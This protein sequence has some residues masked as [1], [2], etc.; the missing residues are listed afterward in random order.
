MSK[1]RVLTVCTANICRS[2]AAAVMLKTGLEQAG[3]EELVEVESAGTTYE[4]E[5]FPMDDRIVLALERAGYSP[6]AHAARTVLV[7]QLGEWDLVLT[8][9]TKHL[10]EMNRKLEAIP[11][12]VEPPTLH[13][14]GEFDPAKP[15]VA[16]PED[17]EVPDPFYEGQK[18]FDRTVLKM[19]RAVPSILLFIK[20]RLRDRGDIA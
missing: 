14:W 20:S 8:M 11:E 2:P 12:G 16:E 6:E 10:A 5:G 1:Y 3:L 9:S 7:H 15:A 19:E 17:L 4:S 13:M 18:F